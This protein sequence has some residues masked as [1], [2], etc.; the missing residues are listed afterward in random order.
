MEFN[1]S[2]ICLPHMLKLE[3][4]NEKESNINSTK[5]KTTEVAISWLLQCFAIAIPLLQQNCTFP[6]TYQNFPMFFENLVTI[7]HSMG[8]KVG[9]EQLASPIKIC[10]F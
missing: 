1:V 2:Y 8:R 3:C 6:P 7:S 10:L 9:T 5:P 4:N